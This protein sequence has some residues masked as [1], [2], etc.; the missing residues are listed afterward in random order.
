TKEDFSSGVKTYK[1]T[2]AKTCDK[3]ITGLRSG[4][5]YYVQVRSYHEFEGMTYY[6]QWSNTLS[7][8]VQ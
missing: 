7:K 3:T 2:N 4:T 8:K 6:G 1:I 5:Y